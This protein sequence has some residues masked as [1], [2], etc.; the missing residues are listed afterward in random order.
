MNYIAWS[1]KTEYRLSDG[2][3]VVGHTNYTN[4]SSVEI[5]ILETGEF[6]TLE[7]DDI[8]RTKRI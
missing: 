5:R 4:G 1:P 8:L 7:R 6:R 2:S 3:T